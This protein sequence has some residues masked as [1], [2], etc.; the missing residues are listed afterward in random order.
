[1]SPVVVGSLSTPPGYGAQSILI[2]LYGPR[3]ERA[4]HSGAGGIIHNAR[5]V[6]RA[7]FGKARTHERQ[8]QTTDQMD[9]DG[10]DRAE[11]L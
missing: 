2:R 8:A 9:G 6:K 11:H 3:T 10:T 1:M 7:A 4:G 5:L